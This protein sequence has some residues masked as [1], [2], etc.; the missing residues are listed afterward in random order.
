MILL[1]RIIRSASNI[2]VPHVNVPFSANETVNEMAKKIITP[3][4]IPLRSFMLEVSKD[5]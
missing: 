4:I 1:T 3:I 2:A 5:S